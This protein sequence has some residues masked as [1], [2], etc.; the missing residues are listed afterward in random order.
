MKQTLNP[1]LRDFWRTR[2]TPDGDTVIGRVLH[3]GRMSSKS[4]DA[5][6][7]AI[8]RAN[9][10]QET[11]LCTRMFQNRISD[12]VYTLLKQ[13]IFAF[14]L[15]NNFKI[16]ADAIEHKMNGSIFRFYGIARNIDEIKSFEGATVWWN[17]ESHNLAKV[18]FQTIRPT[19]MRNSE[20]EMWFTLNPYLVTDYSYQRLV[21]NPP[22]G[23]L[24]RQINYHENPYLLDSA[25]AD[26]ESEFEEDYEEAT[27]I[28]LGVPRTSDS[29]S[30]IKMSWIN[31]AVDAHLKLDVIMSGKKNV[32]Y[33]VA[34]DGGDR[35]SVT[36]FNGSIAV[37][38]DAWKAEEDQL[39]ES[40]LRAWTH[41]GD[42]LFLY[43]CIGIGAGTGS[44]LKGKGFTTGYAKFH[45]GESVKDPDAEYAH[46]ITNKDK[47]ENRKAQAW[48][49]VADRF[50]NTYNAIVKGK[51]YEPDQLIS[52]S[53]DLPELEALKK[54]L[55]TPYR[56]K[57]GRDKDMVEKKSSI[58][59]RLKTEESPDL[60]DSFIMGACPHLGSVENE[61]PNIQ[62]SF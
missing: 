12:S 46:K 22:K 49:S 47:F 27:Y 28:Y 57:S 8:A 62:I 52:L 3:G 24:V 7:V 6:G 5:A 11:F 43:D 44:T 31:A 26:I 16:Y 25:I 18:M 13:K 15:Q 32:G 21:A 1:N 42:G 60:A 48:Q 59:K 10:R 54:E 35:C 53:S 14:G 2:V 51:K 36:V 39:E 33:D 50:R 9:F 58:K 56:E 19:V 34:D 29:R 61:M 37:H 38:L 55:A 41:A 4:H 20:A 45:A 30:I 17:E 40:A 23:F